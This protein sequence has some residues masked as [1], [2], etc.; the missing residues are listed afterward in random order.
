M[1]R[2]GNNK[3]CLE[4]KWVSPKFITTSYTFYSPINYF[5]MT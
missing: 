1:M 5:E 2:N 3:L 4:N